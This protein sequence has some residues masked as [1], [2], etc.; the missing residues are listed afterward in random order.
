M[1]EE[2]HQR[3]ADALNTLHEATHDVQGLSVIAL[4]MPHGK[5]G[6]MRVQMM[7]KGTDVEIGHKFYECM[8]YSDALS[9]DL[10]NVVMNAAAKFLAEHGDEAKAAFDRTY[11][12]CRK[13]W[14]QTQEV[15]AVIEDCRQVIDE[16]N[17]QEDADPDI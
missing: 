15:R 3:I 10:R 17:S 5:R 9:F 11:E 6:Q 4:V 13:Q 2:T 1:K 8:R 7:S 16:I 12:K 14:I